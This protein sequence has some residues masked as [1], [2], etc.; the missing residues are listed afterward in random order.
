MCLLPAL[1]E[2]LVLLVVAVNKMVKLYTTPACPYCFTLK[3]F[4]KEHKV[5]FQEVD[6]SQDEKAREEMIE[7]SGQMSAPV[8]EIDGEIVIGFDKDKISKLLDIR[9]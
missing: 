5:K 6:V 1:E 7:K 9:N 3:E 2:E 8:L 4:L